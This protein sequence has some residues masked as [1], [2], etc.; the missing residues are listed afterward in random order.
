MSCGGIIV[1]LANSEHEYHSAFSRVLLHTD[2]LPA[3][4]DMILCFLKSNSQF[5]EVSVSMHSFLILCHCFGCASTP[6][7]GVTSVRKPP[8]GLS[9]VLFTL[10]K[11]KIKIKKI[12]NE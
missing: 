6:A 8:P 9:G 5:L 2:F 1:P 4:S 10:K 12:I 7:H 11:I 3:H